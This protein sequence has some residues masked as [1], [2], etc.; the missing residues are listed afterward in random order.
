MDKKTL[1]PAEAALREAALEYH[2]GP[3]H[4]AWHV[5]REVVTYALADHDVVT[6]ITQRDLDA[7]PTHASPPFMV[8]VS[9]APT[10]AICSVTASDDIRSTSMIS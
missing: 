3:T 9:A 8:A 5:R 10:R 4:A 1:S 7:M 2:R 6:A